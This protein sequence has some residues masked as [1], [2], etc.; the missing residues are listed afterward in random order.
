MTEPVFSFDTIDEECCRRF[1]DA[2]FAGR[3]LAIEQ[4]L[5][6]MEDSRYLGTLFELAL[7]E[8]ELLW[9]RNQEASRGTTPLAYSPP[10]VESYLQRFPGLGEPALLLSLLKQEY[11]LRRRCGESPLLREYRARFPQLSLEDVL[12]LESSQSVSIRERDQRTQVYDNVLTAARSDQFLADAN[13]TPDVA[14]NRDD[15][16]EPVPQQIGRY[17]VLKVL[18]EGAFGCVYLAQDA[19]LERL[20]AIKTPHARGFA[21]T[22]DVEAYLDEARNVARLDHP[23]IVPVYD[24]GRTADGMCYVVSKYIE[25]NDLATWRQEHRPTCADSLRMVISLAD[26]LHH[27]H[28]RGLVHRDIKPG[29]ILIDSDNRPHLVDFG[30]ALREDRFGQG[31][32]FAGTPAY[33]SSEQA[34]EESHLVDARADIFSLGVV[35]YELLTGQRPF[36]ADTLDELRQQVMQ[37]E[38]RPPRQLIDSLPRE[39][40]R[41]CL[42]ALA[43]NPANRYS[44]ALDLGDDL[45]EVLNGLATNEP[46]APFRGGGDSTLGSAAVSSVQ[47]ALRALDFSAELTRLRQNFVG[48]RWLLAEFNAWFESG[49]ERVMLALGDPGAGKSAWLAHMIEN[50]SR[51]VAHHFCVASVAESLKPVRFVQSLASQLCTEIPGFC[52]ALDATADDASESEDAGTLFRRL[53]ADPLRQVSY[54]PPIVLVV[55]ALDESLGYGERHIA[56]LL[57]ERMHDLPPCVRLLLSSRRTPE[58]CD[59]FSRS[60]RIELRSQQQENLDD[61]AEF[62][63][64]RL[65]DPS[66]IAMRNVSE[67]DRRKTLQVMTEKAAGNFLYATHMLD[68]LAAGKVDPRRP[69]SFPEGLVGIYHE[70]F[71]QRFPSR[72]QFL[73]FRSL[74]DIIVAAREPLTA[75]ELAEFV[76]RSAFE[77]EE[78]L[79]PLAAFFP[80][81]DGRFRAFH[82]SIID[83]LSGLAGQSRTFRV[84]V[85]GGHR[86]I[87]E[88][89]LQRLRAGRIDPMTIAHL[90]AHLAAAGGLDEM[91]EVLTDI[92]FLEAKA[93]AG[94]V[95]ELWRTVADTSHLY[96]EDDPRRRVLHLLAEALGADMH[97]VASFPAMLFA[98]LWNRAWWYDTPQA[99]LHYED[100]PEGWS[101]PPP[102]SQPHHPLSDLLEKMRFA[103]SRRPWLRSLRPPKMHLGAAQQAVYRGHAGEVWCLAVSPNGAKLATGGK[104]RTVRMWDAEKGAMLDVWQGHTESVA[105]LAFSPRGD[106]LASAG[107]DGAVLLRNVETGEIIARRDEAAAVRCVAFSPDGHTIAYGGDGGKLWL[108]NVQETL[109]A[110]SGPRVTAL[111]REDDAGQ[112]SPTRV[113]SIDAHRH[114]TCCV[115]FSRDGLRLVTGGGDSLLR[116][117]DVA[118]GR[119]LVLVR[120][121]HRRCVYTAAFSS[122]DQL[123]V[124]GGRD[125]DVRVWNA[126]SGEAVA[127]FQGHEGEVRHVAISSDGRSAASASYDRVVR[128]WDIERRRL[129]KCLRGHGHTVWQTAFSAD[130]AKIF[131]VSGDRTL[132]V[133]NAAQGGSLAILRSHGEKISHLVFS[134]RG[135]QFASA[136]FKGEVRLWDAQRGVETRRLN[137]HG[138]RPVSG[139][140]FS[141]DGRWIFSAGYDGAVGVWAADTG[142]MVTRLLGHERGIN[143]LSISYDGSRLLTTSGD[144]TARLWDADSWRLVT[145]LTGHDSGVWCAAFSRDGRQFA[146][147]GRDGAICL[148]EEGTTHPNLVLGPQASGATALAFTHDGLWLASGHKDASIRLW[149]LPEGIQQSV[150]EGHREPV[151][152]LMF[153]PDNRRLVSSEEEGLVRE[154]RVDSGECLDL[155]RMADICAVA[156]GPEQY[157][158]R[159]VRRAA[160][161]AGLTI[162]D[163][164]TRKPLAW[165]PPRLWRLATHPDGRQWVG[166]AGQH[167]Y[168][169]RLED[170]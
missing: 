160:C 138:G 165:Y 52:A 76:E 14:A 20:V 88:K 153:S 44:T 111:G 118:T 50:D 146:T 117:W 98:S 15:P 161:A 95:F 155:I 62:I 156:G 133:W 108:W 120:N 5:P 64:S 157:P 8:M 141:P 123:I 166:A 25:G 131:S 158:L 101:M 59:L 163:S 89:L 86:R 28:R 13:V 128:V 11:A 55:D 116:V 139:L 143:C 22:A 114:S 109:D 71:T 78:S 38:A 73:H 81:H 137:A 9:K 33:M 134:P 99:A 92:R 136:D 69:E 21:S 18:G 68:A 127:T 48:R 80:Q 47:T 67:S 148:Y 49:H 142:A 36:R 87:A 125:G 168:L 58:V 65:S 145:V 105:S 19:E 104:D 112:G 152:R 72:Q 144:G 26:A 79:E 57:F 91:F 54:L 124:S 96:S 41:I 169:F 23:G 103:R 147:A 113:S 115:A 100:P 154:W 27:A 84:D 167:V 7:V 83:W 6:A 130:G 119:C 150:L 53:V 97:F 129:V 61:V 40:D 93:K 77:V 46:G 10:H 170:E 51:A 35:L 24:V 107:C 110:R 102:W 39:L 4:C 37:V 164:R 122:D 70:F 121:A 16:S 56:R 29:N 162:E 43:K 45:R 135:S 74:L 149:R 140:A 17:R 30:L 60:R 66:W 34:R 3:P 82:Q 32:R 151:Q 94:Q 42:Q 1:E 106:L 85:R 90:P 75:D 31:P 159:A 12:Q 2:W 132:R 126:A 63:A